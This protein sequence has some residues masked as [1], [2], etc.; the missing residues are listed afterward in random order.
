MKKLFS[1]DHLPA[2]LQNDRLRLTAIG[3]VALAMFGVILA[4]FINFILGIFLLVLFAALVGTVFYALETVTKNT[5]KY[6]SDLSYRIKRGEQEALIKMPIGILLYSE[7]N[8]IEWTNPYL[9]EY[10]GKK[11]VLGEPIATIDP[12]LAKLIT[13][14][15]ATNE[16]KTVRWGDNQ[17]E[18]II[19]EG[20]RVVYLLDI[21]RYAK[22]EERYNE[23]QLAIGQIFLDNYDEITQTM[24]DKSI[25]NLNNYVTNELSNWA[26]HYG[27]FLKRVD[28]DHF[29]LLTYA[30]ALKE[31]EA[32]NFKILDRI[33]DRTSKQNYPLTLS[34]GIANGDTDLAKLATVSQS[35][36]DLALGRGGDQVVV[37][38]ENGQARFYGGKTNPMEKRTRVRARMISQALQEVMNQVDQVFVMG[39]AQPDMDSLGACLGIRRIAAMNGKKCSIV[40]NQEHVHTDIQRLLAQLQADPEIGPD[41]LTPDQAPELATN[42]SLL[43]MVDHSKPSISTSPILYHRLSNRTIIIDHHRRGE[44]F[45]ENP[46][47]VYIEPYASSTC[48]LITEMFE[49]QPKETEAINKLEAT[50]MLAGITVDTKSFSL[51]TGT[52]TFDAASYLRSVGADA[53]M[54]QRL[55]KENVDNYI[56]K[57]HL[58]ESIEFIRPNMALCLGEEDETYDPVIAAQ[59]ADTLL[60]LSGIDASFVITRR[61]GGDIGISARSLGEVNVQVIMEQLG[62]GGHLSNAAT[63]LQDST[64]AAARD[65]LEQVITKIEQDTAE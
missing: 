14:N 5:N 16:P 28:D 33:R 36:L 47:L 17:F 2:F 8:E 57:N 29:F 59:A 52:R 26:R 6:I 22:I 46:M 1:K 58:I 42:H 60:S 9:Q 64:V 62:G 30:K 3:L 32:D 13:E 51:R 65:Q 19:Q 49:Y 34:V 35:N 41:I 56:Q 24:T 37:K 63:Q 15:E 48:E 12:E 27:M 39:H 21:T 53:V 61:P 20:I 54:V 40:V 25:S 44:E 11:E 43:V 10:L 23:E 4:F 55:L 50:A 18:I 45:P 38:A 7:E 31:I